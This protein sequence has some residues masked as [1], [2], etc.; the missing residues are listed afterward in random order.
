MK[1]REVTGDWSMS[2][3]SGGQASHQASHQ[4]RPRTYHE[5]PTKYCKHYNTNNSLIGHTFSVN[6]IFRLSWS[7][8]FLRRKL[9]FILDFYFDKFS[10][11]LN[12][13]NVQKE[14]SMSVI[15]HENHQTKN[16]FHSWLGGPF[17]F[18][19]IIYLT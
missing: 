16:I 7:F 18:L 3:I 2:E 15:Y 4:A 13:N 14:Y 17:F 19:R 1:A 9:F 11:N 12:L 10:V 6:N 5:Q 8:L